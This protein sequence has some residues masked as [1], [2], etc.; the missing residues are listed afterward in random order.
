MRYLRYSALLASLILASNAVAQ[1]AKDLVGTWK[2][3]A[4]D[5]LLPDGTRTLDYGAN[6]HGIAIFTADGHYAIE[7]YRDQRTKFSSDDRLKVTADEYKQTFLTLSVHFGTYTVDSARGTI[8]FHV[9]R[10]STPN[11]DDT[12]QVRPFELKG[13]QLSWKVAARPDG[14]IP[15]T[16][17]ERIR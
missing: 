7:I 1:S 14:S 5:K 8:A 12:I 2:L 17:L 10:A 13:D 3:I 11:L 15:I 4:A 9:D 6:P 16:V